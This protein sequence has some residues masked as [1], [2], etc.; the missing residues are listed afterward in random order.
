MR[1]SVGKVM[2]E[3][4]LDLNTTMNAGPSRALWLKKWAGQVILTVS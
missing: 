2:D 1:E 3:S 4:I